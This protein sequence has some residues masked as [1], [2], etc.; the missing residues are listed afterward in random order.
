MG[1]IRQD[2]VLRCPLA[3]WQFCGR[4]NSS[5]SQAR[6]H[7]RISGNLSLKGEEAFPPLFVPDGRPAVT[8][9]PYGGG[10]QLCQSSSNP[11]TNFLLPT[12]AGRL[13][14]KAG[15]GQA[16]AAISSETHETARISCLANFCSPHGV[17]CLHGFVPPLTPL[18]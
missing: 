17:F 14:A 13:L 9:P 10:R 1:A 8:H 5:Q 11:G 2:F 7:R 6:G 4:W 3:S 12:S 18:N 15:L 16:S